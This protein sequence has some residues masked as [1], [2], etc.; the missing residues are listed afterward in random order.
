MK[1]IYTLTIEASL[2]READK[3]FTETTGILADDWRKVGGEM[4]SKV[5]IPDPIVRDECERRLKRGMSFE[6]KKTK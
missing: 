1:W 6:R 3:H 4:F 5:N 2:Y